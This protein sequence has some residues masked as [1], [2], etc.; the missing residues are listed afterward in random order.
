MSSAAGL[1]LALIAI[2]VLA[3]STQVL[4]AYIRRDVGPLTLPLIRRLNTTGT[5]KLLAKDQARAKALKTLS[6]TDPD[7]VAQ[8]GAIINIPGTDAIV[9]YTVDVSIIARSLCLS[10]LTSLTG[11]NW[12]PCHQMFVLVHMQRLRMLGKFVPSSDDLLS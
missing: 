5:L 3:F 4:G 8:Q 10:R 11:S 6:R 2:F 1:R 9:D 12:H 7:S